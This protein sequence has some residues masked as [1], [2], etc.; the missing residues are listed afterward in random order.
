MT[1]KTPDPAEPKLLLRGI[2]LWLTEAM[3]AAIET[4]A[5]RLLRHEPR[6]VRIRIEVEKVPHKGGELQFAA[7]GLIEVH[8]P[9]LAASVTTEDAYK[10]VDL[11]IDRLD[12]ML[13]KRNTAMHRGR[14]E[15]DIRE[16]VVEENTD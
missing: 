6:I 2:H 14:T 5:E 8:G 4:K 3:K 9:D 12:R 7:K 10:S 1:K 11:L 15:D 16:H 13:R